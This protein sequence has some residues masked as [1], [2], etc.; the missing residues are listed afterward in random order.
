MLQYA[1]DSLR[2]I[3]H[4]HIEV[5]LI[6]FISLCVECMLQSDHVRMIQFLHDLQLP[7]LIPLVL[8]NLLD[9]DLVIVFIDRGLENYTE[10]AVANHTV[11]VVSETCGLFVFNVITSICTLFQF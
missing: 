4:D 11:G 10:R 6:R 1:K 3:V 8:I 9:G 5:D 7:I 2:H